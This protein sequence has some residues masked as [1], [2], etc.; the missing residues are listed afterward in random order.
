MSPPLG[1]QLSGVADLL[2]T[3]SLL[4]PLGG[5][6]PPSLV[7]WVQPSGPRSKG[8]GCEDMEQGV[9]LA[10]PTPTGQVH[11]RESALLRGGK[12]PPQRMLS[13]AGGQ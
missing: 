8:Q 1:S 5:S 4:A 11:C 9:V 12:K 6:G 13:W 7:N 2:S 3:I 10:E